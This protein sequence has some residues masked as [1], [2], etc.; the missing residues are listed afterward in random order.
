MNK[1]RSFTL[2]ALALLYISSANAQ[3]ILGYL[4]SYRDPSP[5]YIQYD[6]LTDVVFSFVNPN[7]NGTLNFTTSGAPLYNWNNTRWLTCKSNANSNGVNLWVALGGADDAELRSA[8]LNSVTGNP[9]YRTNLVNDLV[10]FA[11]NEG[12][13]GL[14]IDWEFPKT[15]AA[16]NN[17]EAFMQEL[18]A[19]I[20]A[21]PNPNIKVAC[22]VGAETT[23]NP[24]HTDYIN[25]NTFNYI[26][27]VHLM[28]YDFPAS[29]N[30]NHSTLAD[31]QTSLQGWALAHSNFD[32]SSVLL[33][34]P[35][36]GRNASRTN[37]LEYNNFG[38]DPA[39]NFVNDSYAGYYY[40]GRPTL[41][42]KIDLTI[43][44]GALGLLIWDLGQDRT[45]QYSLLCAMKD[46]ADLQCP[47]PQPNLGPDQGICL[48][49]NVT[50]DPGVPTASGRT[51]TW[52]KDGATVAGPSASLTTYNITEG[53]SYEVEIDEPGCPAP[54]T[55]QILIVEG[56]GLS[57]TGDTRCGPGTVDL[58]INTSGGPYDWYDASTG[59]TVVHTGSSY[60]PSITSTTTYY[61]QDAS[62]STTYSTGKD[63]MDVPSAWAPDDNRIYANLLTVE[64]D[65][66]LE[67]VRLWP[68]GSTDIY[69][70]VVSTLDGTTELE[71]TAPVTVST[72]GQTIPINI[73]L[74]PGDYFI[75]VKPDGGTNTGVLLDPAAVSDFN[76]PG[77]FTLSGAEY[78]DWGSGFSL[79][80]GPT[81]NYGQIFDWK[82]TTGVVPPCGREPVTGTVNPVPSA[83]G[84][85]GG[86]DAVCAGDVETYSISDGGMTYQWSYD[87][88]AS[89]SSTSGT[90]ID[91]DF[92]GES[93]GDYTLSV[94]A[95]DGLGCGPSSPSTLS[96][97]VDPC[98]TPPTA[99]F[100]GSSNTVCQ[101]ESLTFTD[102]SSGDITS[103]S[104]DFG[105]A[106]ATPAST[107]TGAGPHTITFNSAGTYNI[108]L[109]VTGPGGSDTETKNG[110]VTVFEP[111]TTAS[112]GSDASTCSDNTTLAANAPSNGTGQWT[113]I[114]GSGTFADDTDPNTAVSGLSVGD[115]IFE[116]TITASP[117]CSSSSDQVTITRS[118]GL[119][120][121]NAGTDES[122]CATS[123]T[124]GANTPG[125]GET[126]TWSVIS[127]SGTFAD[128]NDEN[129]AVSGLGIGGNTFRWTISGGSCASTTDDVVITVEE[130]PSASDAGSDQ[131]VCATN[132]TL[133][134]TTPSVGTGQWTVVSGSGSFDD[135]T[136]PTA[137]VSGLSAG[138]NVLEWTVS[139]G[140]CTPNTSQVTITQSGSLTAANAGTD[141]ALCADNATLAGNA[142]GA[143][144]TGTW[145]VVSGTGSFA[146]AND[147][148]TTVSGLS[149]GD[150]VFQWTIDNGACTPSSDVVT[151][152]REEDPSTADAGT[153]QSVCTTTATL[154]AATPSIGTGTWSVISGSG[155]FADAT[156]PGTDVSGLSAGANVLQWTVSNGSCAT[157]T[158]QVTVTVTGAG[159]TANAGSDQNLCSDNT[160]LAGNAVSGGE[161]GTWTVISGAGTFGNANDESTSVTGLT[162][163]D[164]IFRWTITGSCGSS[165]DDVTI[166]VDENPSTAD[167]GADQTV[168]ATNATLG[169]ATPTVGTGQWSVVSGA[170]TFDDDTNPSTNVSGLNSG[171][172]VFE[173]TVSNGV[174]ASNSAQVTITQSGSLTAANA[175]TNQSICTDNT[176][177]AGNA[178]GG[179]ET[180]TWTVV[181][182]AGTFADANNETTTVSGLSLGDNVFQWT[183]DNG[184]CT[185]SSDQVTIT[186]EAT[187]T[188]PDAG[189][190][191]TVCGGSGSLGANTPSE[192]TG[193]WSIVSGTITIADNSSATS[194]FSGLGTGQSATLSWTISNG[195]GSNSDEV[196]ITEGC[197]IS[198]DFSASATTACTN[199]NIVFTSTTSGTSG[200]ETYSWD[201]GAGASPATA[202]GDGPH[203]VS[204]TTNGFKDVSLTVTDGA[205]TTETKPSYIEVI[206]GI[207]EPVI[208]GDNFVAC[209]ASNMSYT[210]T[211]NAGSSYNW[212]VPGG[213]TL[214]SGQ[215]SNAIVVDFGTTSGS[216]SV[217]EI[218]GSCLSPTA[219]LFINVCATNIDEELEQ[220]EILVYPNPFSSEVNVE[221]RTASEFEYTLIVTDVN[222]KTVHE[223]AYF[224][225]EQIIL[226][227]DLPAGFYLGRII[228]D[229]TV[230]TIKLSK[231]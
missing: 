45:D 222:G 9:T 72:A 214:V 91:I 195:C 52:K 117:F 17:H 38:G 207:A 8:R 153:D 218:N 36:Y 82:I 25:N 56:S 7:T 210:V 47:I 12:L 48:P 169:A 160:T 87:G 73:Q 43:N 168:C 57:T 124:L 22:A 54:R 206:S 33:G 157:S 112:A 148:A 199:S 223:G 230:R 200:S 62:T 129:T 192:G 180:G 102:A 202:S 66:T 28:A 140:S 141:Q 219:T 194:S 186:Q 101:G 133:A 53:G 60:S 69:I 171:A 164:N 16:K 227:E 116:W 15:T 152:T 175:G 84:V 216:V 80:S 64:T 99:D 44:E 71:T 67:S 105:D 142:A 50:L 158:S 151:I 51:F 125:G 208:S 190:D 110:Y 150:N 167:A 19:A 119:T 65:L 41:E 196:V 86:N 109:T 81:T 106:T 135:D 184:S 205:P 55:D 144:E 193:S 13:Y 30:V 2:A 138:A 229:Q 134:A 139:N 147:E 85:I 163:G 39:T 145:T 154:G 161:T 108:E 172:N 1:I 24:A 35:F 226:G 118:G 166:T 89:L 131:T 77:V 114:S 225:N 221:V 88:S 122:L 21:S 174:C 58:T 79:A 182:G 93:A 204:Y 6:K 29:A 130:Q 146:N 23:T 111:P 103:Y 83:P 10:T 11:V 59:G 4:P 177:L 181:S 159:T 49:A 14:A 46:Y 97:N 191:Q 90:S 188:T 94:T 96:I 162:I 100:T 40:N 203:T 143:G 3:R 127:G 224:S 123:T 183:I 197:S 198:V 61:V 149:V 217:V 231:Q 189:V 220:A 126:G 32:V 5:T 121:A 18:Y 136:S 115:N 155:T 156:N 104:W 20:A 92:A 107:A 137:V 74:T 27:E 120:Q 185:P 178:A 42:A 132:A 176:T 165:T 98:L 128:P 95:D 63:V 37:E 187:P 113:V 173:W 78:S 228:T 211:N 75:T 76:E 26:D 31:A 170:G 215:G 209:G 179:G 34:V 68:Q 212:G 213:A 201:F 70:A